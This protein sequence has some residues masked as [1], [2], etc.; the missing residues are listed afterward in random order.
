MKVLIQ[1]S[2]TTSF[3]HCSLVLMLSRAKLL[4]KIKNL[5]KRALRFTLYYDESSYGEFLGLSGSCAMNTR[6][7]R[8]L[9]IEIYKTLIT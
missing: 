4:N 1:S 9:C 8:A 2:V 3:N 7:K 6:F 5:Q